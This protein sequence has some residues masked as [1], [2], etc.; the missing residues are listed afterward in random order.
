MKDVADSIAKALQNEE[1]MIEVKEGLSR[2][3][4]GEPVNKN[5]IKNDPKIEMRLFKVTNYYYWTLDEAM[6]C[7]RKSFIPAITIEIL[8]YIREFAGRTDVIR[9]QRLT[10]FCPIKIMT[11]LDY[12]HYAMYN[13]E[14]SIYR[15]KYTWEMSEGNIRNY[16]NIFRKQGIVFENDIYEKSR[17]YYE[18]VDKKMKKI[19][20]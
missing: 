16:Y 14:R 12:E 9:V 13:N 1:L 5:P 10:D 17:K 3:V 18:E 20:K 15:G 6:E 4:D 7:C 19:I 8:D 11:V 2:F